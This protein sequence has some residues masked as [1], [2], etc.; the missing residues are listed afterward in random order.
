M[1]A[2]GRATR[3]RANHYSLF[4]PANYYLR[5]WLVGWV[6]NVVE[7]LPGSV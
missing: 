7:V 5:D 4:R 1:R 6:N 3:S 2:A